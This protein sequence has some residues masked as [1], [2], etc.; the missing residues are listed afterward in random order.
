MANVSETI[1]PALQTEV[2]AALD[3]F[4]ATQSETFSVTGIVDADIALASTSP[5]ELRLVLC[6]GDACLQHSFIVSTAADPFDVSLVDDGFT[7]A[8]SGTQSELDPPPGAL[9]NWLD[10]VLEKHEFTLLIFYRGFW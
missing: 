4:N 2:D 1:P 5:R 9:R 3:W 7:S 6:G 8:D 10:G